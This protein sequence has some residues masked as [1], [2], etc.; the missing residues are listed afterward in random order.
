M[1]FL[2]RLGVDT[3]RKG[4]AGKALKGTILFLMQ[5]NCAGKIKYIFFGRASGQDKKNPVS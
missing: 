4:F 3:K 5:A 2:K 1:D